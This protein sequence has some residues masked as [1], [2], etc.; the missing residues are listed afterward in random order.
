MLVSFNTHHSHNFYLRVYLLK[1]LKNWSVFVT[2]I[3]CTFLAFKN[4]MHINQVQVYLMTE[5]VKQILYVHESV[6][7][8]ALKSKDL[9]LIV[10]F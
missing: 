3:L 10:L 8:V 9:N 5:H 7:K 6:F 2:Q 1:L 4:L